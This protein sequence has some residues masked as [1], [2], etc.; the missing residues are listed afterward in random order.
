MRFGAPSKTRCPLTGRV[1]HLYM[2]SDNGGEEI[3]LTQ[4]NE[5][6]S[7]G[8]ESIRS[9]RVELANGRELSLIFPVGESSD[10]RSCTGEDSV[11]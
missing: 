2:E 7:R 9:I 8:P 4:L 6:L 3:F 1:Q 5:V 10:G 11:D